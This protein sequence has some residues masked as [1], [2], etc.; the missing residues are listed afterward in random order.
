MARMYDRRRRSAIADGTWLRAV[1][2]A[3]V[4]AHIDAL[5]AAGW[6][7]HMIAEEAK[8][9]K[10]TVL[11]V[12]KRQWVQGPTAEAIFAVRL[13]RVLVAVPAGMVPVVGASRRVQALAWMGWSL[14]EQA[15]RVGMYL[16]Q[17]WQVAWA[18]QS[19]VTVAT[20]QTFRDLFE[21]LSATRGPSKRAHNA[22]VR[23]G[24]MPPL[25]WD[26]L[27]N[28]AERPNLGG[29]EVVADEVTLERALQGEAVDLTDAERAAALLAGVAA[30]EAVSPMAKRLGISPYV[31]RK[32]T[33]GSVKRRELQARV[34]AELIRSGDT[35]CDYNLGS[36]LG[37]HHQT[38]TRARARLARRQAQ[39][40]S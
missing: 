34:E 40:A 38:V 13:R 35:H 19:A 3:E 14:Q 30:G 23:K 5:V 31:A 22:A 29:D 39:L 11:G 1:D 26:D 6:T 20:D 16:Q 7:L 12:R 21:Q 9:S 33:G 37:V 36:L 18:K 25:A 10:S 28:P 24:W 17:V 27:D 32:I 2:A 8:L 15:N 4:Q